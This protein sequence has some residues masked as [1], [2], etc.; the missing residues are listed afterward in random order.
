MRSHVGFNSRSPLAPPAAGTVSPSGNAGAQP[1]A[2]PK[3][4]SGGA[5]SNCSR[6]RVKRS[7]EVVEKQ[8]RGNARF[9]VR[10]TCI[11]GLK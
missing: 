6:R 8:Q 5:D 2:T 4:D 1:G 11:V 10:A 7:V 3:D 9:S